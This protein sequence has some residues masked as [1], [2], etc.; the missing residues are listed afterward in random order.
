MLI[1]YVLLLILAFLPIYYR[2]SF[3]LF[4]LES[5]NY[6]LNSYKNILKS[7]EGKNVIFNFWFLLEISILFLSSL[8]IVNP[9]FEVIFYNMFF[10]FLILEN[11]FVLWKFFRKKLLKPKFSKINIFIV[12]ILIS[13]FNFGL[14]LIFN[15]GIL[16]I[17]YPYLLFILLISPIL[18]ILS[19]YIFN[20]LNNIIKK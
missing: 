1:D 8:L 17:L 16:Q 12:L 9:P 4:I 13:F 18:I 2:Y 19:F 11:I 3:W 14:F 7:T 6:N 10:Y 20:F 5:E 15:L